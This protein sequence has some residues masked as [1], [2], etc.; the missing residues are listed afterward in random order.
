MVEAD[1]IKKSKIKE[2]SQTHA[3]ERFKLQMEREYITLRLLLYARGM[4]GRKTSLF[5]IYILC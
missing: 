1:I 5:T 2:N 4:V 3:A